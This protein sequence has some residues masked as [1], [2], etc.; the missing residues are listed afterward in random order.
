V[1]WSDKTGLIAIFT[2][3]TLIPYL[4]DHPLYNKVAAKFP[5]ILDSLVLA[6]SNMDGWRGPDGGQDAGFIFLKRKV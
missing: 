4:Q 1:T 5:A 3:F 2:R 6:S